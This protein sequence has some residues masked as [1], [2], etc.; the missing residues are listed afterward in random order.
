MPASADGTV[1]L[2]V[3]DL[4]GHG[5]IT[6]TEHVRPCGAV[7][8]RVA[9]PRVR[10]TFTFRPDVR[11]EQAVPDRIVVQAGDAED[12]LLAHLATD[13][14]VVDGIT[15][16]GGGDRINLDTDDR[17]HRLRLR[18]VPATTAAPHPSAARLDAAR[19][20]AMA[21]VTVLADRF[22]R[23]DRPALMRA[24]AVRTAGR[25]LARWVH[26][27]V[28]PGWY[29]L[30]ETG[31]ELAAAYPL[32]DELQRLS[33]LPLLP[34]AA[35]CPCAGRLPCADPETYVSADDAGDWLTCP[36]CHQPTVMIA[37][38]DSLAALLSAHAA[39]ACPPTA[40]G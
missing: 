34:T 18:F 12:Q 6:V 23:L 16:I 2:S 11:D 40:A 10:G 9:G 31:E 7:A 20:Y 15:L 29:L 36:R 19:R 21:V 17:P 3:H 14:P 35:A 5:R 8:Y 30:A 25:R 27:Q 38:G 32:V 22:R 26:H 1:T 24:A 39:H 37:P 13:L 28:L 33:V 4:P